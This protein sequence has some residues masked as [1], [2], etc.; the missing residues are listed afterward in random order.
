VHLSIPIPDQLLRPYV[1]DNPRICRA[2]IRSC[3]LSINNP[4][5]RPPYEGAVKTI[6]YL[7]P[8]QTTTLDPF[9]SP[10]AIDDIQLLHWNASS[11][12]PGILHE[13]G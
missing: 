3:V 8:S 5:P 10:P 1:L 2:L 4:V 9:S 11:C 6:C 13:P 12:L 7:V